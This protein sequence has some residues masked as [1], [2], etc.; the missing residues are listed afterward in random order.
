MALIN[1][2]ECGNQISETVDVCIHCGYSLNNKK[3]GKFYKILNRKNIGIAGIACSI[4]VIIGIYFGFVYTGKFNVS[5]GSDS[6]E[7]GSNANLLNYL[8]YDTKDI[9]EVNIISDDNFNVNKLGDYTVVY[10]VKNKKGKIKEIPFVFHVVDTTAPKLEVLKESIYISK[11]SPFNPETY[12]SVV[13]EG[14]YSIDVIGAYDINKEGKYDVQISVKDNS[15]NISESK[16]IEIVVENRDNCVVRNAK[17]GDSRE[18]IKRYETAEILDET[19]EDEELGLFYLDN[20]DGE[21]AYICYLFNED[22]KLASIS[23]MFIENHTDHSIYIST[24]DNITEKITKKYGEPKVEKGK[25]YL[26]DN[27]SNE[28]EALNI[29]QVKYRNTWETDDMSIVMYLAKDNYK[30]SFILQYS[31]KIYVQPESS[32]FN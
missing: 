24:F 8:E 7:L 19:A 6:I 30:I 32:E 1:C 12:I 5:Q 9:L 16:K 18:I 26:Y 21:D 31:S 10:S 23:Y 2:P 29:G 27:C 15:G 20:V 3:R 14:D 22:D 28:A 11:G 17:F 13:E 25:G 4:F